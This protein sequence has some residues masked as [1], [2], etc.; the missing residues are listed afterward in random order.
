MQKR[1]GNSIE[2]ILHKAD[3]ECRI[4][5]TQSV[6]VVAR[7]MLDGFWGEIVGR[8]FNARDD[9]CRIERPLLQHGGEMYL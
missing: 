6:Q 9:A 3:I 4:L 7:G 1:F 8:V 5:D 2:L